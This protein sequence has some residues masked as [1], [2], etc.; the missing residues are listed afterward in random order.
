MVGNLT[1]AFSI[2]I[3]LATAFIGGVLAKRFRQPAV[4]GYVLAGL[5]I[6]GGAIRLAHGEEVLTSL[7]EIGVVFLLFALGLELSFARLRRVGETVLWGGVIQIL[8]I[9]L[10][11]VLI[12]PRFGFDFY[13]SLFLGCA[14]ALSSTAVVVKILSERGEIDSLPGEIMLGWLLIQDLVVLPMMIILPAIGSRSGGYS[15]LVISILKAAI[16]LGLVFALGRKLVPFLISRVADLGS[17]ELLLIAVVAICL[18]FAVLTANLGLSAALGAFLAGLI[19]AETSEHH[20]VFSEIR[21]LRDVFAIIFFVSLGMFLRPDFLLSNFGQILVIAL[22]VI[23]MKLILVFGLTLYLGYHTKTAFLTGMGLVQVGEF[24]FI[25]AQKGLRD[26]LI[27][28]EAYSLILSV[29]L[30]T[31]LITPWLINSAPRLYL[32]LRKKTKEKEPL[33]YRALFTR[34]DRH[35]AHEEGLELS[36][37]VVVC[38]HGRVGSWLGRALELSEIPYVVIDYN[39]Q[40]ISEL[41]DKGIKALYG[42]PADIDVLDFAQ[43]EKARAVVIAIPDHHTRELVIQHAQ[44]LNPK[45]MIICR[46][47]RERDQARLK[48]LGVETVIQPEFEA[49]LS[50]I[51]RVLQ[52]MGIDR[53]EV[54]NKIKRIKLEHGIK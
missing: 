54:A 42:D 10:L 13:P 30:L 46:T 3:V 21:P 20:A 11:G 28:N 34:F 23:V 25:L 51:H 24:A 49:A 27:D 37:H 12:F 39:H 18:L 16:L 52:K 41:T 43:V 45:A 29:A 7:A 8:G 40:V 47:H 14:F 17:R 19:I 22:V 48:A 50:M 32:L 26:Q 2:A 38:G 33:L 5:I 35:Q 1:L 6:G 15:L 31:I 4:L 36:G 44:T 53:E 9:I